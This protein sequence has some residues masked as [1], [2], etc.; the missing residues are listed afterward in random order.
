MA[1][2]ST[3]AWLNL[4]CALLEAMSLFDHNLT[5]NLVPVWL[6]VGGMEGSSH[7]ESHVPSRPCGV[8]IAGAT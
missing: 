4:E 8:P 5:W 2:R 3:L 1:N 7:R 6:E